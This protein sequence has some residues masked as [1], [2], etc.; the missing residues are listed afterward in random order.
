MRWRPWLGAL[1]HDRFVARGQVEN[2]RVIVLAEPYLVPLRA[3]GGE[4]G[5]LAVVEIPAA[6]VDV[7]LPDTRSSLRQIGAHRDTQSGTADRRMRGP[8]H[9]QRA[10]SAGAAGQDARGH[11][12]IP[13]RP[14]PVSAHG[15]V[16]QRSAPTARRRR[17]RPGPPAAGFIVK[18]VACFTMT[19]RQR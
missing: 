6:V 14:A 9:H 18:V 11:R 7:Y 3:D 1:G 16:E 8:G 19:N 15:P 2:D 13:P 12:L 10:G 4:P 5:R 17:V